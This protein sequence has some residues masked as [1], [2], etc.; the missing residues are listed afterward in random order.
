MIGINGMAKEQSYFLELLRDHLH[1][2]RS[3]YREDVDWD[4]IAKMARVHCLE[5]IIYA[6]SKDARFKSKYDFQIYYYANL[7]RELQ[8]LHAVISDVD[9]FIFK[10]VR[11]AEIYPAPAL[12][13]MSDADI[14]VHAADQEAVHEK[15]VGLGYQNTIKKNEQ[16]WHYRKNCFEIELHSQMVFAN[17]FQSKRL[18]EFA[19]SCWSHYD[20]SN[21]ALDWN[22]HFLYVLMHLRKHFIRDG[23]GFRQFMDVAVICSKVC[24]DWDWVLAKAQELEMHEFVLMSLAF[25]KRW[26]DVDIPIE[27]PEVS[28][29]FY[30][31]T[32]EWV[33]EN[34]VFGFDNKDNSMGRPIAE[35]RQNGKVKWAFRSV[36]RPYM[37][38]VKSP[39]YQFLVD[40]RYLL[41]AAWLKRIF[42]MLIHSST[43]KQRYEQMQREAEGK[44][45]FLEE[46][47]L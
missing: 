15:I 26:F 40:R 33:F 34:G 35:I 21:H 20:S 23:V 12:R 24:I 3:T 42:L 27:L 2:K 30:E 7:K 11:I 46:W 5:P 44:N 41:P 4:T 32:T 22:F 43:Y 8:S 29:E 10:G 28:S 45:K 38:L 14:L 9:Y 36:F 16:V 39:D 18:E 31:N 1:G 17:K 19:G 25:V 13:T 6:Q 47:G 37:Q